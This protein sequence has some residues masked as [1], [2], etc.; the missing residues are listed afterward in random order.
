MAPAREATANGSNKIESSIHDN[1]MLQA[2]SASPFEASSALRLCSSV[3]PIAQSIPTFSSSTAT[4]EASGSAGDSAPSA[5]A[6][7]ASS[8]LRR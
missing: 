3:N 6:L 8:C 7:L 2:A 4:A 1:N 5:S